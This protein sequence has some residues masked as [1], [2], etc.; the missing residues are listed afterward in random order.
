M[1]PFIPDQL[2]ADRRARA[3]DD[4]HH[5]RLRTVA[6]SRPLR[7]GPPLRR[8]WRR[9]LGIGTLGLA[10]A[11]VATFGSGPVQSRA[12]LS[13]YRLGSEPMTLVGHRPHA[14]ERVSYE[15]GESRTWSPG[16]QIVGVKVLSGRL[17]VYG[18]DGEPRVYVAGQGYAAGWA[19]YRTVNETD[20]RV[21]T[22]VTSHVRP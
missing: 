4:A 12:D 10:A 7:A 20:G 1:Y 21:E 3:L 5:T 15:P 9:R 19:G 13:T 8:R 22:L 16:P 17:T 14:S 11:T 18:G 6:V 2:V